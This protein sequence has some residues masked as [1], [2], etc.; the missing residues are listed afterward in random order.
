MK[1]KMYSMSNAATLADWTLV[2]PRHRYAQA[3]IRKLTAT[4][5]NSGA[6]LTVYPAN[7]QFKTDVANAV[8]SGDSD[9]DIT[10]DSEGTS[11]VGGHTI[12]GS[13]FIMVNN[14]IAACWELHAVDSVSANGGEMYTTVTPT[15]WDNE[16]NFPNDVAAGS[17]VYI[18]RD[19]EVPNA[20]SVGNATVERTNYYA[21]NVAAP[22]GFKLNP[23]DASKSHLA[24]IAEFSD[25][26]IDVEE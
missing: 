5:N 17:G 9:I 26:Q 2:I 12:T 13:D 14:P 15:F 4:G 6:A 23:G 1:R 25:G 3:V 22:L 24:V 16:T 19:G 8:T 20:L 18:V 7:P 10:V 21:G 11:V